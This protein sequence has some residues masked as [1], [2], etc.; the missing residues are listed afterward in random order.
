MYNTLGNFLSRRDYEE[1]PS[2]GKSSRRSVQRSINEADG[3]G[4]ICERLCFASSPRLRTAFWSATKQ[5]Q[6]RASIV[7]IE[8]DEELIR[9][10][11]YY[12]CC[13]C[14][15]AQRNSPGS[16]ETKAYKEKNNRLINADKP[17]Q[18]NRKKKLETY[19]A[20]V[21]RRRT[22]IKENDDDDIGASFRVDWKKS[23]AW[24]CDIL[25]VTKLDGQ[26]WAKFYELVL[27]T[28]IK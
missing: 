19:H 9:L 22:T 24:K 28:Q 20:E 7:S 16:L 8:L 17:P 12:C 13:K 14:V 25:W 15:Y 11:R 4:R 27:I 2:V 6:V 1:F 5:T 3:K 10:R 18:G 21:D 23:P 26:N